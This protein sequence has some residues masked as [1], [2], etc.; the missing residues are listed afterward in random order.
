MSTTNEA[1]P[2]RPRRR[3]LRG[4]GWAVVLLV[5][6]LALLLLAATWSGNRNVGQAVHE[7]DESDPGWRLEDIEA[8]RA[9]LPEHENSARLVVAAQAAMPRGEWKLRDEVFDV[10]AKLAANERLPEGLAGRLGLDL[11]ARGG[12]ALAASRD[13]ANRPRG[14]HHLVIAPNPYATLL[15]DVQSSREICGLWRLEA[16][17][18]AEKGDGDAALAAVRASFNAGR[19]VGDEPFSISQLV[20]VACVAVAV[21]GAERVLGLSEPG[22]AE[23]LRLQRLAEDEARHPAYRLAMRGERGAFHAGYLAL[24]SGDTSVVDLLGNGEARLAPRLSGWVLR[25]AARR[26]Y[27]RTLAILNKSVAIAEAPAEKQPALEDELRDEIRALPR[28]AVFARL[29]VP[30]FDRLGDAFRRQQGLARALA[31]ALACERHRRATGAWPSNLSRLVPKY[32]AAVPADPHDGQPLRYRR[33][34]GGAVV[35]SVGVDR[36]D[37][38]GNLCANPAKGGCDLGV[39]L[40][41]IKARRRPAPELKEGGDDDDP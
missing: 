7:L 4:L 11:P 21:K 14:R 1:A 9:V 31:V 32:L 12:A 24:M 3:W 10:L 16:E 27:P 5:G 18:L 33:E 26:D 25:Q 40:Y 6:A 8:A 38:G 13:L 20:R 37:N 35:Y 19:S 34:A 39:R 36:R 23:L 2:P 30:A 17:R 41:D 28:T 15:P 22:D 29:V